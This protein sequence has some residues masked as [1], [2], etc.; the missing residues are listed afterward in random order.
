M[1]LHDACPCGV[2]SSYASCCGAIHAGSATASTAEALMRARY[3]AFVRGQIDFLHD[4]L[5]TP[6]RADFDREAA[7]AWA[8]AEWLGL[9][10]IDRSAG[11]EADATGVVEFI[12]RFLLKGH[13]QQH[14]ERA[15]F[16]REGGE[17]RYDDGDLITE[18][19]APVVSGPKTGRNEACP[20]GSGRKFKKCCGVRSAVN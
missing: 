10:I 18:T 13:E 8:A 3:S 5:A 15:R 9:Q 2:A 6:L 12:A 14:R 17:W 11:G 16:C 4:S 20:C 7:R 1:T 19:H